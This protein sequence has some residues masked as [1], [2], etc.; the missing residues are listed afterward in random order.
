MTRVHFTACAILGA[1][2][3]SSCTDYESDR[4]R[5]RSARFGYGSTRSTTTEY[6]RTQV[7]P[8]PAATETTETTTTDVGTSA[9]PSTTVETQTTVGPGPAKRDYQYGTPVPGKPGFVTSPHAPYSGYV[10]VRGFPPGTEVK[11]P[12]TSKIFLVP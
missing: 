3:F 7:G 10:D 4:E 11:D 1:A 2:L 8:G 6:Q 9:P 12:Y 5:Q